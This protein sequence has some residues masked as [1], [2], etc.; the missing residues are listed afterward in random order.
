MANRNTIPDN[1]DLEQTYISV[2]LLQNDLDRDHEC[3]HRI[4]PLNTAVQ[5]SLDSAIL[6]SKEVMDYTNRPPKVNTLLELSN[7]GLMPGSEEAIHNQY[8]N[9]QRSYRA[10]LFKLSKNLSYRDL[11]YRIA[12]QAED[13]AL[14]QTQTAWLAYYINEL[15]MLTTS[16]DGIEQQICFI[17][18]ADPKEL[19]EQQIDQEL[20]R[21]KVAS[22][23]MAKLKEDVIIGNNKL[24]GL[25]AELK[26]LQKKVA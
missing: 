3:F 21:V 23:G 12:E 14:L 17:T 13:L 9:S 18:P 25:R 6:R 26:A 22:E 16:G 24:K 1:L 7:R 10:Y 8:I 19:L 15:P 20:A 2:E 4:A 5:A 11:D